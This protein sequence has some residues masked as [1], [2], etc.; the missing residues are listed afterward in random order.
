MST[1]D[2]IAALQ[3]GGRVDSEG[4]F[5]LN[6]DKAREKLRTFQVAEP[7]KYVLHLV[8]LATLK[9]AT[10]V[11]VRCD[12]DDVVIQFDGLP[13][14]AADLDDL[15]S[16]SFS[17]A[18]T[19]EQRARQQL[20][21]GLH[22]AL[23]LN[24]RWVRVTSG[25]GEAAVSM[26]ARHGAADE[27]G[28]ALKGAPTGTQIH[29]KS[30][31]RPGLVVRFVQQLRGALA[32]MTWLRERCRFSAVPIAVN[33]EPIAAGLRIAGTSH[34]F[35]HGD[36]PSRG[37]AGMVK[38]PIPAVI[39]LVRHGVWLHDVPAP[40]LPLGFVAVI[41][42]DLLVTDLSGD[43]VVQ[44]EHH[45]R[46]VRL[47]EALATAVAGALVGPTEV[48]MLPEVAVR[49]DP[50][51]QQWD[52]ALQPGTP[53]G[54]VM[55]RVVRWPDIFGR[56][57]SLARLH[58]V[59][60]QLGH[61]PATLG[62]W[63][64]HLPPSDE[65]IVQRVDEG[66]PDDALLRRIFGE[67]LRDVSR[68]LEARRLA[69][70][71]RRRWR[72]QPSEGTLAPAS[73]QLT[74]PFEVNLGGLRVTGQVG[75]RRAPGTTCSMKVIVDGCLLTDIE[76]DAPIAGIDVVLSRPLPI[77]E[78]FSGPVRGG[79]LAACLGAWLA[80][81]R[82]IAETALHRGMV[83]DTPDVR[84]A[85]V[86]GFLRA[87][88][89]GEAL[90]A[91]LQAT[92]FPEDDIPDHLRNLLR[93]LP[94]HPVPPEL[95][96]QPWLRGVY[97]FPTANGQ[98]LE[99]GDVARLL[100]DGVKLTWV[101]DNLERHPQI[102]EP[103]LWLAMREVDAL[104]WVFGGRIPRMKSEDYTDLVG[105]AHYLERPEAT[106]ILP[107]ET[108]T[109]HVVVEHPALRIGA[110]FVRTPE[111]WAQALRARRSRCQ[112][113]ALRRPLCEVWIAAPIPGLQFAIL[114]EALTIRKT[115]DGVVYDR[116]FAEAAA[117]ATAAIPALVRLAI[118]NLAGETDAL[119]R[120]AWRAGILAA[121]TATFPTPA[122]RTAFA[123]LVAAH[124]R[125]EAEVRYLK[126]LALALV[127]ST[128]EMSTWIEAHAA[129]TAL[130]ADV[131]AA[132]SRLKVAPRDEA[133]VDALATVL[134]DLRAVFGQV[135]GDSWL[136]DVGRFSPETA[137]LPLLR[138]RDGAAVSLA[139]VLAQ[140]E[141]LGVHL[142]VHEGDCAWPHGGRT[143]KLADE[144]S[145]QVVR[146]LFNE[147]DLHV[148]DS[149]DA[150]GVGGSAEDLLRVMT[151]LRRR[152][153][154]PHATADALPGLIAAAIAGARR[155]DDEAVQWRRGLLLA[156]GATF[157]APV[158]RRLF[159]TLVPHHGRG[160]E[161]VY[162]GM[163]QR[164]QTVGVDGL[165]RELEER[166]DEE[167]V[168][169]ALQT[170]TRD[171]RAI[172]LGELLARLRSALGQVGGAT[173]CDAVAAASPE[174]A[175]LSLFERIDGT[176]MTLAEVA[177]GATHGQIYV[178]AQAEAHERPRAYAKALRVD[179][180]V[181]EVLVGMFG[182]DR[183]TTTAPPQPAG[184]EEPR[185]HSPLR[186][187]SLSRSL[188]GE[189]DVPD[190]LAAPD[191]V[192]LLKL[193]QQY[194]EPPREA[195]APT[196]RSSGDDVARLLSEL[197]P[198]SGPSKASEV[199]SLDPPRPAEPT[200]ADRLVAA[201]QGELHALRRGH[202]QLLTG[203]NLDHVRAIAGDGA[204]A[205]R[206]DRDGVV[207]DPRHPR[208]AEAIARWGGDRVWVSFLVS[209]VYTALNVWREDITDE[210]E[211]AFHRRHLTWLRGEIVRHG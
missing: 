210:D 35:T 54:T 17:A 211:E 208:I 63:A 202:E 163:L 70:H 92:Q 71:N 201:I 8:A 120:T 46:C 118:A 97:T 11:H 206:C 40:H 209:Q 73:Y 117:A 75:L 156:L 64:G 60:A 154:A 180:E 192:A 113:I 144:Q 31:F 186:W 7:Q 197:R 104:R 62:T 176:P 1:E 123:T 58:A 90:R 140:I 145:E 16:S 160:A 69:E 2:L 193:A 67:A 203:F 55:A 84:L 47:A 44:D 184:E 125:R 190:P 159:R 102:A 29:V 194:D 188:E 93:S 148:P 86:H 49:L 189:R 39:R 37:I 19:D 124:G 107:E 20:A 195:D 98:A 34:G 131:T 171:R 103:V 147:S 168:Q 110:A 134:A 66:G 178:Y 83:P 169:S 112:V 85:F 41:S 200:A 119:L 9:K 114:G 165:A 5:T 166:T 143:I 59:R 126:I 22:A 6:R 57:H 74:A 4:S 95:L 121:L 205:V 18:R 42:D 132:A 13:I 27:I 52:A 26:V 122:W 164:A 135:G 116:K 61:V 28:G 127:V 173:L 172:A 10:A 30:R 50:V 198:N 158:C 89:R 94:P 15:Y 68:E 181:M 129:D 177:D 105:K 65:V 33:G 82:V 12:S 146:A 115:W 155:A 109:P 91:L 77:R 43:K 99:I 25:E 36:G 14:T 106:E 101:A 38:R 185:T 174:I 152:M 56:H 76:I 157:P 207:L 183:V 51:W 151:E 88:H 142:V 175:G 23:A 24:P 138:R 199:K 128:N 167:L 191:W 3:G 179:E 80:S 204:Q 150:P 108:C 162:C 136:A 141:G 161:A 133:E 81:A 182:P 196:M 72:A 130:L 170:S 137:A 53:I 79:L 45:A 139:Q 96:T 187:D 153:T 111:L 149:A 48:V 100:A 87:Y 21:V 32:E 78:D